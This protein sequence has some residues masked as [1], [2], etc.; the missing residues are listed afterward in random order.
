MKSRKCL[1]NYLKT[2]QETIGIDEYFDELLFDWI[3]K[4]ALQYF[5][6]MDG[7][8]YSFEQGVL[9]KDEVVLL[10]GMVQNYGFE[11]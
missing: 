1:Y 10:I 9:S 4:N 3:E 7:L 6:C 5:E 11:E 8:M 2:I